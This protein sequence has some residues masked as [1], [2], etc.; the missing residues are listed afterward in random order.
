VLTKLSNFSPHIQFVGF[1]YCCTQYKQTFV[2]LVCSSLGPCVKHLLLDFHS[3]IRTLV[4][5]RML[6]IYYSHAQCLKD[7]T[8]QSNYNSTF[9][10]LHYRREMM[11]KG[12]V[13]TA[14]FQGFQ[15]CD[16]TLHNLS[17]SLQCK[18]YPPTKSQQRLCTF[19]TLRPNSA[20]CTLL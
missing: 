14:H 6:I 19:C 13:A 11:W 10:E 4:L 8:T 20:T 7:V 16:Y 18:P 5:M 17:R 1:R 3:R 9:Y 15:Q 2:R 12:V